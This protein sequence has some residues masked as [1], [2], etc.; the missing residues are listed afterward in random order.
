M[1]VW[2]RRFDLPTAFEGLERLLLVA[3]I[4]AIILAA[5]DVKDCLLWRFSLQNRVD[6]CRGFEF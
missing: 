5:Y 2:P 3:A 1:L 4:T 6:C